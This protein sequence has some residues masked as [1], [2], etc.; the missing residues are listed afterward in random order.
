MRISRDKKNKKLWLSQERYIEKMLQ[1]FNMDKAKPMSSPLADHM[2]LSSSQ[3]LTGKEDKDEMK[4]VPYTSVVGSLMYAMVCTRLD[5][6]HAVGV[7]S[8][9]MSN[10]GKEHWAAAKW[11][12]RYLRGTS[13]VYLCFRPGQPVLDGYIDSDMSGDVD[14]SKSTSGYLMTFV[15]TAVSW[16]LR[17]QKC[18]ALSTIEAEYIATVEAG[19]ELLWMKN[20]PEEVGLN[21]EKYA[22]H[23]DSQSA[24]QL[25][26]NAAYHS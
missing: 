14:S 22:L 21:Q 3:C 19:K 17:L 13:R 2:K 1:K 25:A 20:F 10:P 15:G 6:A 8:R 9:F 24:I 26:K 4:K 16:Q 23:C 18:V 11:I 5:I 7:V 12:L